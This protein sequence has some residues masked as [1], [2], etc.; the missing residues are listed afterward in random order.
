MKF[1]L[2]HTRQMVKGTVVSFFFNARGADLEKSTVGMYRSLLLQILERIPRLHETLNFPRLAIEEE[3]PQWTVKSLRD[4]FEQIVQNL[5]QTRLV[6]FIDALDECNE[7]QIREMISFFARLGDLASSSHIL[8]T[9]CFASRHYP[10]ITLSRGLTL[11]LDRQEGHSQD[12]V[13]YVDSTL[14]IGRGK[15]ANEIR[16]EL[17]EKASGVFMWVVLVVGIL[18]REHDHG[19]KRMLKQKL[20]DIPGDL[21]ELFRDI[22]TRDSYH[23][24]RLIL[25][26]QWLLFSRHPLT[27]KQLYLAVLSGVES[28]DAA[29]AIPYWKLDEIEDGDVRNFIL[30]SSKGLAEITRSKK[31]QTVQFIHESVRDF[32]L[33]E[34]GLEH[35][36]SAQSSTFDGESHERLTQC[37]LNYMHIGNKNL[38]IQD[39]GDIFS[40]GNASNRDEAERRF[41]FLEYAVRNVFYHADKAEGSGVCQLP[42]IQNFNVGAWVYLNNTLE[43]HF[44]RLQ[45]NTTS[46]LYLLSEYNAA[47]LIARHPDVLTCFRKEDDTRYGAPIL[48]ALA[49]S[50]RDAVYA[51]IEAFVS[52]QPMDCSV[53]DIWQ[54]YRAQKDQKSGIARN[55][56][57]SK[58]RSV[59][60]YLAEYGEKLLL[61]LALTSGN[62]EA[63]IEYT[64]K[65]GL[66][67]LHYAARGGQVGIL[68][69]L[70]DGGADI[71]AR[72]GS[73]RTALSRAATGGNIDAVKLLLESGIT[74]EDDDMTVKTPVE[75][76]ADAG[77]TA[78]VKLLLDWWGP[79]ADRYASRPRIDTAL[80]YASKKGHTSTVELLLE[81]GSFI[82]TDFA[83]LGTPL[84]IAA[85]MGHLATVRILLQSGAHIE[86]TDDKGNT[87]LLLAVLMKNV[88]IVQL[89]LE[90]KAA[91]NA[92]DRTGLTP[93]HAAAVNCALGDD[94]E[95]CNAII[96]LLLCHGA[97]INAVDE[98]GLTP[99]SWAIGTLPEANLGSKQT[100]A[101]LDYHITVVSWLLSHGAKVDL[102][103]DKG[104]TPLWW[105][106][107]PPL[108]KDIVTLLLNH[109]ANVDCAP[110]VRLDLTSLTIVSI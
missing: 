60:S 79:D 90:Q 24:D 18:Q 80:W 76:A 92:T 21:H 38:E 25:C 68:Q 86:A 56:E 7:V 46:L 69:L 107:T 64:D 57:F 6:C 78:V 27:P 22:L 85:D 40:T 103:D 89:L 99:L 94:S 66:R 29:E 26:L 1:M 12:I 101:P 30:S 67:L 83:G 8:F 63:D 95:D 100:Y 34:N 58:N 10:H 39:L 5:G 73:G 72:D 31:N 13:R 52:T 61:A 14:K 75:F 82:E 109:G 50:S 55:F 44:I 71:H 98:N 81:S 96:S 104:R 23:R 28:D 15:F 70:I 97:E 9:V 51:F 17:T 91:V 16:Q 93:L 53:Q 65:R 45:N 102:A 3:V 88:E 41:P 106:A 42:F 59:F 11:N 84:L 77:H 62:S 47:N 108:D 33:K 37:C 32:L 48:A 4:L 36:W 74:S 110:G 20:R 2:K 105:A 54:Q 43:K 87:P 35:I 19:G 49:T